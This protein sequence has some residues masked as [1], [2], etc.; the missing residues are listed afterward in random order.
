MRI[1]E[2]LRATR[3]VRTKISRELGNDPKR[4]VAFYMQYQ[5]QFADRL[6]WANREH[7]V[8]TGAAEEGDPAPSE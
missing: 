2:G 5:Q 4:M 6:R 1:D 7:A 8:A 3:K